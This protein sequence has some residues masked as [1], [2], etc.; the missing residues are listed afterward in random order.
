MKQLSWEQNRHR[1][2]KGV[3]NMLGKRGKKFN[4]KDK[5][6]SKKR[7][8]KQQPGNKNKKQKKH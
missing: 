1:W 3:D 4:N 2:V 5:Q 8:K 6:L 7:Q